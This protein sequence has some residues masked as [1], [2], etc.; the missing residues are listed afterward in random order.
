MNHSLPEKIVVF[1]DGVG[2]GQLNTVAGYEA[3][4]LQQCFDHFGDNYKPKLAITIVQKRINTRI[5]LRVI[6]YIGRMHQSCCYL[7]FLYSS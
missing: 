2:D 7:L 5:F 6:L 1:R 4:Q 3:Q